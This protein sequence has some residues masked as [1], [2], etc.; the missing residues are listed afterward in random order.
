MR[1]ILRLSFQ[2]DQ[3]RLMDLRKVTKYQK[4]TPK[5]TCSKFVLKSENYLNIYTEDGDLQELSLEKTKIT[6]NER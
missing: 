5:I 2:T 6:N 1:V 4:V 3:A